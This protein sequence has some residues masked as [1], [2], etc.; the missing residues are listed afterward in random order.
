MITL[1]LGEPSLN[2][3]QKPDRVPWIKMIQELLLNLKI[4]SGVNDHQIGRRRTKLEN[5]R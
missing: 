4:F 5:Q 3:S 2:E 1:C